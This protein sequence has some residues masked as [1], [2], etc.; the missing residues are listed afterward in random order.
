MQNELV[1]P[2]YMLLID[3]PEIA[4]HPNAVRAARK[5]LYELAEEDGWQVM[6]ST[7]SPA[8][9]DPLSDHTTIVR[10][11]RTDGKTPH[12]PAR[13]E[14]GFQRTMNK[15]TSICFCNVIKT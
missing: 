4:L 2:G 1:L 6:L 5:H 8:F 10:L 14:G 11:S 13:G 3:E 12:V 7:H 15:R 9:I